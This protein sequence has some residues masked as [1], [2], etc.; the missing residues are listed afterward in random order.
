MEGFTS[1]LREA[2]LRKARGGGATSSRLRFLGVFRWAFGRFGGWVSDKKKKQKKQTF[3]GSEDSPEKT[4]HGT[5][6][7][8][9]TEDP[10][11]KRVCQRCSYARRLGGGVP[12]VRSP[13]V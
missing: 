3:G 11:G 5:H 4:M 8:G 2:R 13:R 9:P 10:H 7:P 6:F 12:M 1:A